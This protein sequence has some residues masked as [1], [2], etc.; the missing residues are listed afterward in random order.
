MASEA[1]LTEERHMSLESALEGRTLSLEPW[2]YQRFVLIATLQEAPRNFGRVEL[3]KDLIT[4]QLVAAK[5]MPLAWTCRSHQE[6]IATYPDSFELPWRDIC[7]THYLSKEGIA[8]VCDLIG[9]FKR[10]KPC[11]A[12]AE[13]GCFGLQETA[14]PGSGASDVILCDGAYEELCMVLSY[15]AGADLFLW[16]EKSLPLLGVERE[17]ACRPVLR[18][19]LQAVC[20]IHERG[21]AHGDLSLENILL[22]HEEELDPDLVQIRIIDFGACSGRFAEGVRGKASYQAPEMHLC[23]EYDAFQADA[24]SVGVMMFT[25]AVGNYPWKSTRQH[26]CCQSFRFHAERGMAAFLAKKK[27][28]IAGGA[29][30]SVLESLSPQLVALLT[31][32][33]SV[34]P[35]TRMTLEAALGHTWF[36]CKP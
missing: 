9:V 23:Q 1:Y 8:R 31:G 11:P 18:E 20:E 16:L 30:V 15:C 3:C 13:N 5:A 35:A 14:G 19:V 17:W 21:I 32:L 34:D 6:F 33:L 2:D 22:A 27:V 4:D 29:I 36:Q 25:L 12:T 10:W 26:G 24:F 7:V 28:K